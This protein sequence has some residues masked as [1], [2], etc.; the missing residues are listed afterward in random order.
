M[1]EKEALGDVS[2]YE[3]VLQFPSYQHQSQRAIGFHCW[4]H[5]RQCWNRCQ[6]LLFDE[7][8]G[9]ANYLGTIKTFA[10]RQYRRFDPAE[11]LLQEDLL[12]RGDSIANAGWP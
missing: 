4:V 2:I 12:S 1:M 7:K 10:V 11:G 6:D 3:K 5:F 9:Q 8:S